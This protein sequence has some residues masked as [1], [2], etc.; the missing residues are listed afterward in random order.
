MDVGVFVSRDLIGP[1]VETRS[2]SVPGLEVTDSD[3]LI[4]RVTFDD[5]DAAV[6]N[7]CELCEHGG[8]IDI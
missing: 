1:H 4:R 6:R 5:F 8:L 3:V 2:L 7:T